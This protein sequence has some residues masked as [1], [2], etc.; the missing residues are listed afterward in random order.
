METVCLAIQDT[1]AREFGTYPRGTEM[2]SF[3]QNLPLRNVKNT[4]IGYE[5]V[6][7]KRIMPYRPEKQ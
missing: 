2:H 7:S 1:F 5:V 3:F 4:R 6:M